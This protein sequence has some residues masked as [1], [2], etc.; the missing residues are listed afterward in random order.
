MAGM[1]RDLPDG[2]AETVASLKEQVRS[3]QLQA[4]R[5]VNAPLIELYWGIGQTI[6]ERQAAEPWGSKV[7]ERLAHDLRTEFPHIK[8]FN[9][10]NLFYM[11]AFA[12]AWDG[13]EPV[14]FRPSSPPTSAEEVNRVIRVNRNAS[15]T[16][17]GA[18]LAGGGLGAMLWLAPMAMFGVPEPVLCIALGATHIPFFAALG[19]WVVRRTLKENDRADDAAVDR[20]G[21]AP[22]GR[23][24]VDSRSQGPTTLAGAATAGPGTSVLS[25]H[26]RA[27]PARR[28][29]AVRGGFPVEPVALM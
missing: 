29:A 6:L 2:Y 27:Q 17:R 24:V 20:R 26:G 5:V 22:G 21:A 13:P 15:V 16:P 8:G 7:L 25:G 11:R 1:E 19:G 18:A 23:C 28:G 4:Q 3:A 12:L 14:L 9:R 10:R